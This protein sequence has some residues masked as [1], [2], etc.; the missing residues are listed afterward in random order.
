MERAHQGETPDVPS[1]ALHAFEASNFPSVDIDVAGT[2]QEVDVD[3][4]P[5][6]Q[7]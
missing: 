7:A 2:V 3:A 5:L 6:P 4:F 1:L